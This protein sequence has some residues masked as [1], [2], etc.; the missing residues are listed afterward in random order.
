M[1]ARLQ[2]CLE[3][4][5]KLLWQK[6]PGA[7]E[8]KRSII[9][10]LAV[11]HI[12]LTAAAIFFAF[13]IVFVLPVDKGMKIALT[14]LLCAA[15][16]GPLVAWTLYKWP[17]LQRSSDATYFLTERRAGL[18]RSSGELRQIPLQL[19]IRMML[20]P[21]AITFKFGEEH[22]VTFAGLT[23]E[24]TRLVEALVTAVLKRLKE[25]VQKPST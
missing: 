17:G 16:N 14:A 11:G 12:L 24:E 18:L 21:S 2:D 5:E 23:A 19:G 6:L 20:F 13:S 8:Q 25:E 10:I 3:E 9:G 4:G 22:Q 1:A 7:G 15:M